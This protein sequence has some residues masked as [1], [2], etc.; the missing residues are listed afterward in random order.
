MLSDT[1]VHLDFDAFDADRA[2]VIDRAKQA[3]LGFVINIGIDLETAEKS[4]ML[5]RQYPG[6][7]FTAVGI[8]P[9]YT[10]D[11]NENLFAK[12]ELLAHEPEVLAIGEIGLDYYR[13]HATPE[14]Q[15]RALFPQLDL[16]ARLNLPIIL[17][18]RSSAHELVPIL[19]EWQKSLPENSPLKNHPGV[20]HSY[21]ASL[22]Y[23]PSLLEAG[24]YFGIG[25][26]VTYKN[27]RDKHSLVQSLPIERILLETDCP[28]LTPHPH[29]GERNEPAYIPYIAGKIAQ[30]KNLSQAEVA[31]Q[32]AKHAFTLFGLKTRLN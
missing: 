32:T 18:E 21:S 6:F 27:A 10:S 11:Y 4:I 22:E 25:G 2:Q 12:L 16:A 14:Q 26:P 24:F 15:R 8:H 19:L 28:Y 5:A 23:L 17:H 3:G 7:I 20:L 13:D 30:L 31:A 29:R 1:H 9:N